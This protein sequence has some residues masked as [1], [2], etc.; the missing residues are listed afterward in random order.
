GEVGVLDPRPG[1]LQVLG[2]SLQV[3]DSR[4]EARLDGAELG[5]LRVHLVE[6]RVDDPDRLLGAID[7][8]DVDGVDGLQLRGAG[9]ERICAGNGHTEAAIGVQLDEANSS[10]AVAGG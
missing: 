10:G 4:L 7:R 6:G 1:R 8:A 9:C 5:A 2:R 3:V